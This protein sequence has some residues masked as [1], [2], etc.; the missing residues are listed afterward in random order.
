MS[1]VLVIENDPAD[2]VQRLGDWLRAAGLSLDVRTPADLP[3]GLGGY[4]GL[5]VLGG[6]VGAQD[7]AIA[8]WLPA[9]RALLREAVSAELPTLG[10]CLGA[11]LLAVA[12]G[13]RVERNPDGPEFGAQLVAKRANAATDP[14]F[15]SLPITPD[16]LQWHL[17]AVTQLPPGAI[18]LASSPGCE[19]QAFRLGRLAWGIQF[20]I[21]TTPE[22]IHR[23]AE[24]DPGELAGY[25]VDRILARSDAVHD[26]IAEVWQ[27]FAEAFAAVVA[28]PGAVR[29]AR[30]MPATA[31]PVTDPA[32]IRAALAAEA[33]GA[34]GGPTGGPVGL[35]MPSMPPAR[36]VDPD[37]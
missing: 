12:H 4:A 36:R 27:P 37:A 5:I 28:N 34:H 29:A 17:D 1:T 7:D 19:N 30:P 32:A 21:E 14:L 20:H 35:Q 15:R 31:A 33:Q 22:T 2:P 11:Q 23:W 25:D 24:L 26:D 6:A 9:V 3:D 10:V 16:V 8:P 18:H 13:G